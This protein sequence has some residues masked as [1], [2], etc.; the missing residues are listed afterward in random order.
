MQLVQFLS[1]LTTVIMAVG[2]AI[3]LTTSLAVMKAIKEDRRH[4][5]RKHQKK[6]L[7]AHKHCAS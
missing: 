4:R 3:A 1:W 6:C 7:R 2:V 5:A